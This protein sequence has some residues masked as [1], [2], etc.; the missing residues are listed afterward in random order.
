MSLAAMWIDLGIIILSEVS[1]TEKDKYH[2]LSLICGIWFLKKDETNE[3]VCKTETDLQILKTNWWLPKGKC[4][5]GAAG[6]Y[7]SGAW[8]EHK[9]I[10]VFKIDNQQ[11]PTV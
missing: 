4:C 10:T 1:Q 7:K 8:D 9:H 3:L 6:G 2:M 5:G 11:G